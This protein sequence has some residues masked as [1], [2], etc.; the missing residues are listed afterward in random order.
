MFSNKEDILK[1]FDL[2][3]SAAPFDGKAL[4]LYR[5]KWACVKFVGFEI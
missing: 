2:D 5:T 3:N 1:F 4:F